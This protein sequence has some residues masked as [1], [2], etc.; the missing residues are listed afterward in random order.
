M[1]YSQIFC[2]LHFCMH[3]ALIFMYRCHRICIFECVLVYVNFYQITFYIDVIW[4]FLE[5][6]HGT[7]F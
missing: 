3:T 2:G 7:Y 4:A 6:K 5:S 1:L